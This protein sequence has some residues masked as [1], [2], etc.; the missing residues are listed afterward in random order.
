MATESGIEGARLTRSPLEAALREEPACFEFFEAVRRLER[1]R[2]DCTPL[3]RGADLAAEAVQFSAHPRI[4]FPPAEI[5]SL[6]L[7]GPGPARMSVNFMGLTGASGVLPYHYTLLVAERAAARDTA[8]RDFLDIFH[9]RLLSLF[10]RAWEKHR[11]AVAYERGEDRLRGHVLDLVGTGLEQQQQALQ[12]PVDTLVYYAGLLVGESRSAAALQRLLRDFFGAPVEIEQ[13]VGGWYPLARGSQCE[14]GDEQG[15]A[16]QLGLGA[17]VGDEIWYEQSRVRLRIG[18]LPRDRYEQFLPGGEAHDLLRQL[19][20]YFGDDQ[21]DF[22]LQ[23]VLAR[24]DVPGLALGGEEPPQP[25]GWCTWLRSD[26]FSHD[27]D[28]TILAL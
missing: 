4:S 7:D 8:L 14:L 20:R 18:P 28:D 23:L 9:H 6:D 24:E 16:T 12:L 3:G 17:V 11:F 27:A 10:Y 26:G 21:L 1:L 19:L 25:L 2:P 13:F 15:A 22:E 5:H